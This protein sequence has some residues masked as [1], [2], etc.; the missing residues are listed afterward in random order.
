MITHKALAAYDI[1]SLFPLYLYSTDNLF[2]VDQ[3]EREPNLAPE[4]V[5]AMSEAVGLRFVSD[6]VGDLDETFDPEDVFHY[7][8]AVFHSPAYRER[9]AEFL[10][11][12]FPR[13]PLTTDLALFRELCGWGE[14]LVSLHLMRSPYLDDPS[15]TFPKSGS[16]VMEKAK[17]DAEENRVYINKEGQYFDNVPEE[18]WNFRVGGYQVLDKWLKDRKGRTLTDDDVEHYRKVVAA[19][20]ETA[21]IMAAIDD[22]IEARG[23]WPLAGSVEKETGVEG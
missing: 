10:K 8:Y 16:N 19:L 7:A 3:E 11:R 6:G 14:E 9:Y 2:D 23:G 15:A 17:H 22:V 18:T 4:F 12:D 5:E 20:G 21:Q 1:S 13:L